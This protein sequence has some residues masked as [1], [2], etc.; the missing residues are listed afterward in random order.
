MRI[1][2]G[3]NVED[4]RSVVSEWYTQTDQAAN[5]RKESHYPRVVK[6]FM[7]ESYFSCIQL[8]NVTTISH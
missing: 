4:C 5:A 7:A 6:D 3:I 2:A 8:L 1:T